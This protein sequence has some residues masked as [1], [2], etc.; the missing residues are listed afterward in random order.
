[1]TSSSVPR[2]AQAALTVLPEEIV[3]KIMQLLSCRD[4]LSVSRA[5]KAL[6]HLG[7][8]NGM[9]TVTAFAH[10]R[11][12]NVAPSLLLFFTKRVP[13]GLKVRD[14]A[15]NNVVIKKNTILLIMVGPCCL[16]FNPPFGL[17]VQ[18]EGMALYRGLSRLN[19]NAMG[20]VRMSLQLCSATLT[21]LHLAELVLYQIYADLGMRPGS[22]C[23]NLKVLAERFSTDLFET[24]ERTLKCGVCVCRTP[25]ANASSFVF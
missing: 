19:V 4:I 3:G 13:L 25:S 10:P 11:K 24:S 14:L 5:S 8:G 18:V 23:D 21:Q 2:S 12:P 16:W 6:Y 20:D 7:N 9:S 1:M 22:A 15:K 17:V